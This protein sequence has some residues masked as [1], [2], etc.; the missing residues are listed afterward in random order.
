[1]KILHVIGSLAP[2]YGGPSHVLPE[3]CVALSAM[4][5]EVEVFTTNIDGGGELDVQCGVPV[6]VNDGVH[7]TYHA[8][9]RPR[10]YLAS[11]SLARSLLRR[12]RE[13]DVVHVHSLFLW[14]GLVACALGRRFQVP[15]VIRPHGTL[16]PYHAARHRVRKAL[17]WPLVERQN[18][19]GA[20]GVHCTSEAEGDHVRAAGLT[21]EAFVIPLGVDVAS[22]DRP[23]GAD[24]LEQLGP[25]LQG[26]SLVTF[27]GR[28]TEKKGLDLLLR[29][30]SLLLPVRPDAHLVIAGPDDE[31]LGQ[32]L[33]RHVSDLGLGRHVTMLGLVGERDKILLLRRSTVFA[34][35]SADENFALA[36]VEAMAAGTPVV[37]T[38]GVALHREVADANAGIIVERTSSALADGLA[39]LLGDEREA[40][41]LGANARILAHARY[42]WDR[43]GRD[44]ERMYAKVTTSG[45]TA[46]DRALVSA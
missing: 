1:V 40:A 33:C 29:A 9:Q 12:I 6:A 7:V 17:Y 2:R 21:A 46:R 34:L 44:L 22:F 45:S 8:V 10:S 4:G 27:I 5:H 42:S 35:P 26:K 20:A 31:G 16:D 37:L 18:F 11:T 3:M 36:A 15:Y 41:R 25:E 13:F 38:D 28:L 14:H 24:S 43:V 30:F 23:S 32:V 19:K 39:R